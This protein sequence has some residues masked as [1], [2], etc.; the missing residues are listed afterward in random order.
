MNLKYPIPLTFGEFENNKPI[1]IVRIATRIAIVKNT[2]NGLYVLFVKHPVKGLELPGGC[3]EAFEH[4]LDGALRELQEEAGISFNDKNKV[5][6][7]EFVIVVDNRGGNWIDVV[8]IC[9]LEQNEIIVNKNAEFETYWISLNE[10]KKFLPQNTF[11][12]IIQRY[13]NN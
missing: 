13:V 11:D 3:I 10:C 8:Y 12:N 4:P 7:S 2:S 9:K 6:F 5:F 1:T